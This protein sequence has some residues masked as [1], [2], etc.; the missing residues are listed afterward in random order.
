MKRKLFVMGIAAMSACVMMACGAKD[1]SKETG[2][3]EQVEVASDESEV[4]DGDEVASKTKEGVIAMLKEAYDDANI[5]YNPPEDDC[6]PN[7][8]LFG[9][10]CSKDFYELINKVREV[11]AKQT[12]E[13]DH[14]FSDWNAMWHFWDKGVV[15]PKDF[16]V[17]VDGDKA[18]ATFELT[19][20][21]DSATQV[22]ALVYEDNQWRVD[23]WL[24]RG[25][26]GLSMREQIKEY[27]ENN[28]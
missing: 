27:L 9:M 1:S 15:T 7:L 8:D 21:N 14:F 10:Y 18:E 28:K 22:V 13:E 20:G 3:T 24:Q 19:R 12:N 25:M 16:D 5:I 11:E 4:D 2:S 17:T 23:D 6:E 26:D